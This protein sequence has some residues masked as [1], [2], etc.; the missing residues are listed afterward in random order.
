MMIR[1]LANNFAVI[2]RLDRTIQ[3]AAAGVGISGIGDYRMPD[4]ACHRRRDAP[5]RW[6]A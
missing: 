5:T 4:G 3:D 1:A 2:V 6:R